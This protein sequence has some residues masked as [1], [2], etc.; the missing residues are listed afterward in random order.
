MPIVSKDEGALQDQPGL[1][2]PVDGQHH[3]PHQ[4]WEC[5]DQYVI[6]ELNPLDY[7]QRRSYLMWECI[8]KLEPFNCL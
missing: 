8:N 2:H 7:R 6:E 4:F 3:L 1:P 5:A